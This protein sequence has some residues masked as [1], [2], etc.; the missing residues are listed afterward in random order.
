MLG[1]AGAEEIELRDSQGRVIR[2]EVL[3]VTDSAVTIRRDDGKVFNDLPLER[4]N[5]ESRE[6]V[7]RWRDRAADATAKQPEPISQPSST[8]AARGQWPPLGPDW[9]EDPVAAFEKARAE[10]KGVFAY[11]ATAGCPHCVVMARDT[12]PDA[13]VIGASRDVVMLAIHRNTS[14]PGGPPVASGES[15]EWVVRFNV[16]AYPQVR[17]LDGWGNELEESAR[18]RSARSV[19]QVVEAIHVAES[20]GKRSGR[21]KAPA[22][23]RQLAMLTSA[24]AEQVASPGPWIRA[25]AWREIMRTAKLDIRQAR[26]LFEADDDAVVRME[27]L[28]HVSDRLAGE[29][30]DQLLRAAVGCD[31]DHVVFH[32]LGMLERLPGDGGRRMLRELLSGWLENSSGYRNPNNVLCEI[33]QTGVKLPD[34]KMIPLIGK[35][36]DRVEG[37][38]GAAILSVECLIA[39][40]RVHGP[41][42]VKEPLLRATKLEGP[43][44]Q[45]IRKEVDGFLGAGAK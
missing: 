42:G 7:V 44:A 16:M 14:V 11:I 19:E 29:G 24:A 9:M 3:S 45:S 35:V 2:G 37:N 12:W 39:I 25:N 17:L 4:L 40:G 33:L 26:A 21:K 20:A 36:L 8:G 5:K 30:G 43:L 31:N 18:Y 22:L 23:P 38:N 27:V 41:Q 10:K 1:I 6:R 32:A 28:K 13:A 15:P 34:E